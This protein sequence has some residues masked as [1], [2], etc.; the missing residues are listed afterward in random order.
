MG[1]RMERIP[2]EKTQGAKTRLE[3]WS[4]RKRFEH[5]ATL[6]PNQC[7]SPPSPPQKKRSRERKREQGGWNPWQEPA[8]PSWLDSLGPTFKDGCLPLSAPL[9]LGTVHMYCIGLQ[10]RPFPGYLPLPFETVGGGRRG[11][12][13][14]SEGK[15]GRRG[16]VAVGNGRRKIGVG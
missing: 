4:T 13:K 3:V 1:K 8:R 7:L 2:G 15:N 11:M 6:V 10:S 14:R 9:S 12:C 16:V 5:G